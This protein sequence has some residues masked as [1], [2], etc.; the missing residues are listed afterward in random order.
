MLK[1]CWFE[2]KNKISASINGERRQVFEK[3]DKILVLDRDKLT[4][5]R[6]WAKLISERVVTFDDIF[7]A[8]ENIQVKENSL[9]LETLTQENED[10]KNQVNE[11]TLKVEE[12]Q[13]DTE[14]TET[15]KGEQSQ[16]DTVQDVETSNEEDD[17]E[18]IELTKPQI[19]EQLTSLGV[20]FNKNS[21]KEELAKL[22]QDTLNA[23]E[24]TETP[25]GE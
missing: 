18:V 8:F 5:M 4:L 6:L 16:E 2:F 21:K 14:E 23:V 9:E 15:P 17:V 1:L 11:L 22:L 7:T 19:V 12:L 3:W 13:Q 20:V 25:K 24:E 10:L